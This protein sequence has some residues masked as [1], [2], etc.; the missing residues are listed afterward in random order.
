MAMMFSGVMMLRYLGEQSAADRLEQILDAII[1]EGKFVT[2]DL[3]QTRDDPTA[4]S[5]SAVADEIVR[6]LQAA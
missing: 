2:Y 1:A 4:L 5:T 6:R 3:K